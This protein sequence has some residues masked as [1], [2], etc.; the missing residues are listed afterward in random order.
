[1]GRDGNNYSVVCLLESY[2]LLQEHQAVRELGR[3]SLR[4]LHLNY[5]L[6]DGN[7]RERVGFILG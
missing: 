4:R 2:T 5:G 7:G 6:K 3:V 1:M